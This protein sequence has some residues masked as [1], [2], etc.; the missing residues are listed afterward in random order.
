MYV[1]FEGGAA[2]NPVCRRV[3]S[4]LPSATLKR[5]EHVERRKFHCRL[6]HV[7]P[8]RALATNSVTSPEN[9]LT[10]P[11]SL[12]KANSTVPPTWGSM[13]ATCA[14]QR[15]I[16]SG[17][18]SSAKTRSGG[19]AM[20]NEISSASPSGLCEGVPYGRFRAILRSAAQQFLA[21]DAF[22]F[23]SGRTCVVRNEYSQ[24]QQMSKLG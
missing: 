20:R 24:L 8:K 1:T 5:D 14:N 2:V 17:S 11:L 16:S 19:A 18:V 23:G 4:V 6:C 3:N 15:A 22:V 13:P 9:T 12:K 21:F 10:V 7:K